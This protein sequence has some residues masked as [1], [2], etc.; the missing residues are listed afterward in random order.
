MRIVFMGTPEFAVPSLRALARVHDVAAV[1]TR[2][3]AASGRGRGLMPSAVKTVAMDLGLDVHQPRTLRDPG[4]VQALRAMRPD[5][6]C[7]AAYG[8]ILPRD[9]L[10]VPSS[11]A[12][13]VHASLLPRWRGAAPI[14]RA[15][16]EGDGVTG[17]S[18]MRME[19]GLDTGDFTEVVSVPTD[20][21]TAAELTN[22]LAQLG[23]AALI[24]AIEHIEDGTI[25]WL[26]QDDAHAT[27]APKIEKSDVALEPSLSAR[28]AARR[29]RASTSSAPARLR[30]GD[31]S[32][33]IL[34]AVEAP[35]MPSDLKA[36]ELSVR[37]H[38]VLIGFSEGALQIL[39]VKPEGKREMPATDWVRGMRLPENP[40][41]VA[42]S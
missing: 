41:W 32:L 2:P 6:I 7:V 10:D 34:R 3:D 9:V 8:L 27:Y 37:S 31:R 19:E 5:L 39:S 23:A 25:I 20:E 35:S 38:G 24:R 1:Y 18:I 22:M 15:I 4:V 42:P 26:E 13:N 11:G 28:D 33:T 17:V 21:Y 36:G 14:Q 29:V 40:S 12:L 30:I 16:L